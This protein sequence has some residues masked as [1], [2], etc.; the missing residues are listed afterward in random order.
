MVAP[1][2]VTLQVNS[3]QLF[4]RKM[5]ERSNQLV[6]GVEAAAVNA[7]TQ[8]TRKSR[9]TFK[10]VRTQPV[11]TRAG[12]QSTGGKFGDAITWHAKDGQ[13]ALDEAHLDS[14]AKHY[15]RVQ[16][17]GTANRAVRRI[18]GQP[19]QRGRPAQGSDRIVSVRSQK[20]RVLPIGLA[21]GTKAGG[22]YEPS[23]PAR[24]RHDQIYPLATLSFSPYRFP[25]RIVV[26]REI[27]GQHFVQKGAEEGF[28]H[29]RKQVLAAAQRAFPVRSP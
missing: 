7:A 6:T 26:E 14:V 22:R 15:W 24:F 20:G 8:A 29:Y 27:H 23:N 18:G 16:E 11:P 1:F 13:V 5:T 9:Q 28:R 12:R 19:Q 17:I 10:Y 3:L 25:R 2:K 4:T 21:W